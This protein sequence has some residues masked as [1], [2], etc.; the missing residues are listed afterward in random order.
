MSRTEIDSVITENT[1]HA[2]LPCT[3]DYITL[4]TDWKS[5]ESRYEGFLQNVEVYNTSKGETKVSKLRIFPEQK[6]AP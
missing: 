1:I 6:P 4:Q 2:I 3:L 5:V